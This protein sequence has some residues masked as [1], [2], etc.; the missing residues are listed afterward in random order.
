ML[1]TYFIL[2][3][4]TLASCG[5]SLHWV[6]NP[7]AGQVRNMASLSRE[8]RGESEMI[9]ERLE[10]LHIYYLLGQRNLMAFDEKLTSSTLSE[11]YSSTPYL[12]LLAV[13][14]QVEEIESELRL[15][16]QDL[17]RKKMI[18]QQALDYAEKS[19]LHSLGMENLFHQL[20]VS[21]ELKKHKIQLKEVQEEQRRLRDSRE[22]LVYE[23][24]VEHL[25]HMMDIPQAE[26]SESVAGHEL[27]SKVWALT[28]S[29]NIQ[30]SLEA[31]KVSGKS[32]FR[33]TRFPYGPGPGSVDALDWMPQNS[34]RII[35]RT[36]SLIR[37]SKRDSG[38]IVF[39]DVHPR[40]DDA[41][42]QIIDLLKKDGRRVC[43][44]DEIVMQMNE[45]AENVC[46]LN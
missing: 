5:G 24:N 21:R 25:S 17:G 20:G 41:T 3:I 38:I 10:A 35:T 45:G 12:N 31:L 28:F 23:K 34:S 13:K 26:V 32:Q 43:T 4:L 11:A 27:P 1:R 6:E 9:V 42:P 7:N 19:P 18:I 16:A 2:T 15:L 40:R 37:M 29:K 8:S 44:L 14:I 33:F 22:F 30:S 36:L 39:H 46:P